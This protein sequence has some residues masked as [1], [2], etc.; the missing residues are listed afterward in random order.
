MATS[1]SAARS[2]AARRVYDQ[3]VWLE[4]ES[5]RGTKRTIIGHHCEAHKDVLAGRP[6]DYYRDKVGE[7]TGGIFPGFVEFDLGPGNG[8]REFNDSVADF[9][10]V[11]D[12]VE[13]ARQLWETQV[14]LVAFS[15]HLP[16][17]GSP[18]KDFDHVSRR[19]PDIELGDDWFARVST[20]GTAENAALASDLDWA[21]RM[22]R[23]LRDADVPV[24]FRPFHEMNKTNGPFWWADRP[25]ADYKR[26]WDF[27]VNRLAVGAG[28]DNLIWVWSPYAWDGNAR[29]PWD[30]YPDGGPDIVA[31]DLYSGDP[32][33]TQQFFDT[34]KDYNKP[35][36]LA[37]CDKM[38]TR[39]S[40]N[41]SEMDLQPWVIWSIWSYTLLRDVNH[42]HGTDA[43]GRNAWNVD[44]NFAAV[45]ETYD[46]KE[47]F[48]TSQSDWAPWHSL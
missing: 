23:P 8:A 21:A 40:R 14:G 27:A 4:E 26:L 12:S 36:M 9:G 35:R 24:L 33:Y 43:E 31:I 48:L 22:L 19:Q 32:P 10:Y 7:I 17:P 29:E 39:R 25:H 11:Q 1:T 45:H 30:F 42:E 44:D 6:A 15:F 16:Y 3:L 18:T 34:L 5:R 13:R 20:L 28:L 37:E 41:V 2:Q 38:P 46:D 47:R